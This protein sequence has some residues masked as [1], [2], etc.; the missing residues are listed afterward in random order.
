MMI[1]IENLSFKYN[2][3]MVLEN[4]N[5]HIRENAITTI[6]GPNG[7]GKSTLLKAISKNLS[8]TEGEIIIDTHRMSKLSVKKLARIMAILPQSP[9]IPSALTVRQL[10]GLG[11]YPFLRFG[12]QLSK[13]D[14]E[15][16]DWALDRTDMHQ[17]K[18]R[19]LNNLS[20]G[21]RQRAFIAMALVQEPRILLLDEPTTY[22]DIAYQFDI[23]ELIKEIREKLGMTIVMVLHDINQ[24]VRY[25]DDII[26]MKKGRVVCNGS[27]KQVVNDQVMAEVFNLKGG[28][29]NYNNQQHFIPTHS[30]GG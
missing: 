14:Y 29:L 28:F 22:L 17:Y 11:R 24:A 18:N 4:I 3:S 12:R 2:K 16:I 26:V 10:V 20:G 8:N 1:K 21:E 9:H 30:I 27:S 5:I 25:S 23:L 7:C 13:K 6:I 19:Y 15:I